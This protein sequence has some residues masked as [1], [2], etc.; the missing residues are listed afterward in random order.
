VVHLSKS[1]IPI[2]QWQLPSGVPRG[3]WEYTQSEHIADEYDEYFALNRLFEFDEQVLGHYF[4]HPGVVVDLGTGTGRALIG[5]ARRGFT[6]V[7][8]DLS[9]HMLRIVAEKAGLENLNIHCL[10]ANIVDLDCLSDQSA[11]YVICMFS[12]LGMIRGRENRQRVLK[13]ARRIL[14]PGGLFVM[15][16]H[17]FWFNLFDPLGRRWLVHHLI[18]KLRHEDV[19]WG[20]KFFHFHGIAQMFLHTFSET[21]LRTVL[22]H[23]GFRISQWIPLGV[24]RQRPLSRPWLLGRFRAN[25]W[26]VVCE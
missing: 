7:A 23:A 10:Q 20:D 4:R 18:E 24:D 6:G 3:V 19:E 9:P 1:S 17:N 2:P 12:T 16:V 21:E 5:L 25:G 11:D 13:N 26:I 22:R 8:V 15:H 14:K